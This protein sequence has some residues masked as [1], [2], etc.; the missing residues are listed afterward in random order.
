[1]TKYILNSGGIQNS[2]DRGKAFFRKIVEGFGG[3]PKILCCF[4]AKPREDWEEKYAE[5][6]AGFTAQMPDGVEPNFE[7]A[8]PDTFENQIKSCDAIYIPGG[9]DHL[10]QYWL[11][12]YDLPK[13]W[14][15]KV[16]ST[17]SASSN[18]LAKHFWTCDWRQCMDGMG[19]LPIKF[20][21]HYQSEY[22]S[23]DPRGPIDWNKAKQQLEDYGEKGLPIYA[24][25]EG[26]FEVFE[27]TERVVR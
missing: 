17:N 25:K 24:L 15:G 11:K 13:L 14:E 16:V 12:Q 27:I 4:F 8:F 18:A 1:M 21:P 22:G 2:E 6:T 9:D 10:M 26:E 7:L 3:K 19:I 20:L 23:T 5:Y